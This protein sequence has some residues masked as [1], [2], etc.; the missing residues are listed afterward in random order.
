MTGSAEVA[1]IIRE[2]CVTEPMPNNYR[3]Q[4]NGKFIDHNWHGPFQHEDM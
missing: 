4:L 1:G 3:C 2:E